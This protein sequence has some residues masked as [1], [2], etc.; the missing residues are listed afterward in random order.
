[1][2]E[3][4]RDNKYNLI[5]KGNFNAVPHKN[6]DVSVPCLRCHPSQLTPIYRRSH[7]QPWGCHTPVVED[8]AAKMRYL[9]FIYS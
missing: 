7:A 3:E 9:Q 6:G 1:M 5:G 2:H 4:D 8:C